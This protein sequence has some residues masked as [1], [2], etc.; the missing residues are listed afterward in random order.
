MHE[1]GKKHARCVRRVS[2]LSSVHHLLMGSAQ[3]AD[4]ARA[5]VMSASRIGLVGVAHRAYRE[6]VSCLFGLSIALTRSAS[7]RWSE[8]QNTEYGRQKY[9]NDV[10]RSA[11]RDTKWINFNLKL[12][13]SP[14]SQWFKNLY[15]KLSTLCF[16]C[17]KLKG[18][19]YQK[20]W[21]KKRV[22]CAHGWNF[23]RY[24]ISF[25]ECIII[26]R[27]RLFPLW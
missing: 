3:A 5:S 7:R 19:L 21:N 6:S 22:S 16:F 18:C 4:R 11:R 25:Q 17:T 8:R 12:R 2:G 14:R 23:T 26:F 27:N 1:I 10:P 9:R 13:A 24:A 20:F 15:Y